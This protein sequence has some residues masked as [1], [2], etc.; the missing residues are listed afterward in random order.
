MIVTKKIST[1]REHRW[2]DPGKTWGFVPTMGFLHEGHLSLIRRALDE[3][4]GCMASIFVNSMQ[5]NNPHDYSNYPKDMARDLALLEEVGV[6]LVFTPDPNIMYP[7]NFSSKVTLK[8]LSETLEGAFRPGHFDGVTTVVSKL[9]NI[10]QPNR[11]YFGQKDA[12]QLLIIKKMAEDLNFN[13]QIVGC[14]TCR[15]TDGLAMSSRN[16][17]LTVDQRSRA[18]VLNQSLRLAEELIHQGETDPARIV[19]AMTDL[20][21]GEPAAKTDLISVNEAETLEEITKIEGEVLIS[22][23]VFFGEVRLID[24]TILSV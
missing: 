2:K 23:A 1:I 9:F 20:I 17:R 19:E 14:P 21:E 4:D 7:K 11:A 12:Q 8:G 24:N 16:A 15:E 13:I 10:V 5:F 6:G 18:P 22:L 3:N